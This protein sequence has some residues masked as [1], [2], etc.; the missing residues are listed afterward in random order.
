VTG[1][2]LPGYDVERLLGADGVGEVWLA[3][4]RSTLEPVAVRVV[5]ADSPADVELLRREAVAAATARH[6][7]LLRLRTVLPVDDGVALVSDFAAAG[8]L[9]NLLA[10]RGALTPGE[11]VTVGVPLA[12]AL[13]ALHAQRRAHGG[14][15]VGC[16]L[17][18]GDGR[19]LLADFGLSRL[20]G[21]SEDWAPSDDVLA[22]G[23][24]LALA[25][26]RDA[27]ARL[28]ACV[29]RATSA[30]PAGRPTADELAAEL[31]Q[32]G[33]PA[34]LRLGDPS[35]GGSPPVAAAPAP[36]GSAKRPHPL[37]PPPGK[38]GRPSFALLAGVPIALVAAVL[39]GRAWAVADRPAAPPALE[40]AS[41][42]TPAQAPTAA[43]TP[44]WSAILARLD[45]GRDA[46][47]ANLDAAA[48]NQIYAAG[49]PP[50]AV[51]AAAIRRL[52]GAGVRAEGLRLEIESVRLIR[53]TPAGAVVRVVDRLP[54]YEIIDADGQVVER[55]PGRGS[56]AWLVELVPAGDG[57]RIAAVR[58]A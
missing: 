57:W 15:T 21:R 29:Q 24:V 28:R 43:P 9:A 20:A 37:P 47:I 34:P 23:E 19:P 10:S 13:A 50:L 33:R 46:A 36:A 52:A 3:R 11:V 17:F 27:P 7:H 1:W 30:D 4:D 55:R 2:E 44:D 5:T 39:A 58:R 54:A 53:R 56:A 41:L 42:D 32:T 31:R 14:V 12:T 40:A 8:S 26:D 49:S 45:S 25:L 35:A 38:A 6:P 22:L 48:L 16:V 51:D 18:T